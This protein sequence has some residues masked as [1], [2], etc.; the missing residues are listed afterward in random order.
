[1]RLRSLVYLWV[2][3][4]FLLTSPVDIVHHKSTQKSRSSVLQF[5]HTFPVGIAHIMRRILA[6]QLSSKSYGHS[7]SLIFEILILLGISNCLQMAINKWNDINFIQFWKRFMPDLPLAQTIRLSWLFLQLAIT[8]WKFSR[9]FR[10]KKIIP[11]LN[12]K[13]Q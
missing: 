2:Q 8:P 7:Q 11:L 1:M 4:K 10:L 13:N 6:A 5:Q 12:F 9:F 3:Q